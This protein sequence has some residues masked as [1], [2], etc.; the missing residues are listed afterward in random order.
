MRD[1]LPA[2]GLTSA[3]HGAVGPWREGDR[4]VPYVLMFEDVEIGS[5]F[6]SYKS[7]DSS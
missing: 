5:F 4:G 6:F 3:V 7:D 1:R 2:S